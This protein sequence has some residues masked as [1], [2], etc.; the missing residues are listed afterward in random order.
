MDK[1]NVQNRTLAKHFWENSARLYNKWAEGLKADG[2]D[3]RLAEAAEIEAGAVDDG[4]GQPWKRGRVAYL[5]GK[6]PH[7]QAGTHADRE[8][9]GNDEPADVPRQLCA[10]A[11]VGNADF[12]RRARNGLAEGE[13][14]GPR[15][16]DAPSCNAR[17]GHP[18]AVPEAGGGCARQNP[19]RC[20]DGDVGLN[21]DGAAEFAAKPGLLARAKIGQTERAGDWAANAES[22]GLHARP[23][24]AHFGDLVRVHV[25]D[26]IADDGAICRHALR[27]LGACGGS[28]AGKPRIHAADGAGQGRTRVHE[29][30]P[31][32]VAHARLEGGARNAVATVVGSWGDGGN[33]GSYAAA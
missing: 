16:A 23:K 21:A 3:G 20:A 2:W 27:L 14:R 8:P 18:R 32:C 7:A 6:G 10:R 1:K 29:A 28:G 15:V 33:G 17:H 19:G 11:H 5:L 24:V 4:D 25:D 9:G 12:K 13:R 30:G 22:S 31:R 26:G